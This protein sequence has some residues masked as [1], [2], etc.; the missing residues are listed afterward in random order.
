M[1]NSQWTQVAKSPPKL[2]CNCGAARAPRTSCTTGALATTEIN[3]AV[4][5][6]R[7]LSPETEHYLTERG[8][9]YAMHTSAQ[10]R[11]L[12][13]KN[14]TINWSRTA[15]LIT[16]NDAVEYNRSMGFGWP[17]SQALGKILKGRILPK[18]PIQTIYLL[19]LLAE[20]WG[21]VEEFARDIE[22]VE[23][24]TSRA[25]LVPQKAKGTGAKRYS[26]EEIR[27]GMESFKKVLDAKPHLSHRSAKLAVHPDL[28]GTITVARAKEH[29]IKS[30]SRRARTP[31]IS[32]RDANAEQKLRD[33]LPALILANPPYR[34]SVKRLLSI[35]LPSHSDLAYKSPRYQQ[36]FAAAIELEESRAAYLRRRLAK[37]LSEGT[38]LSPSIDASTL[39]NMSEEEMEQLK[40][41]ERYLLLTWDSVK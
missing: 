19:T 27:R 7:F 1:C 30:T 11:G 36:T 32:A 22:A 6:S 18:D 3:V 38:L 13:K 8:L 41:N 9:R 5:L 4:G 28:R 35:A 34:F 17:E 2:S 25:T 21:E 15:E 31:E 37:S 10:A 20:S 29:G 33:K 16:K 24:F 39:A 40:R 23:R 26:D 14:G 12:I